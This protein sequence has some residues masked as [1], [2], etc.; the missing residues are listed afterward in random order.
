[1]FSLRL[2]LLNIKTIKT[3]VNEAKIKN[4]DEKKQQRKVKM[5]GNIF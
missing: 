3:A 1:M 4:N 2:S 5:R